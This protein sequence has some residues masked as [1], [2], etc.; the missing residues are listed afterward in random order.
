MGYTF[1][2]PT[3]IIFS[4]SA[5]DDLARELGEKAEGCVFILADSGIMKAGIPEPIVEKIGQAGWKT[6]LY[7]EVKGNP[8]V[9]DVDKAVKVAREAGATHIVSIGGGSVID[10]GKAVSILLTNE[11]LDWEDLQWGRASITTVPLPMAA[12]PTT[13]GTGSEVTHVAVIGDRKGFKKGVVHATIY[14]KLTVVDGGLALTLPAKLTAATGMDVLVHALEAYLGKRANTVSDLLALSAIKAVVQWL[15]VATHHG[16]SLEARRAMAQAATMGGIAFDQ[17]GLGLCHALGGPLATHYH[18]HHGLGVAVL[19][20]ATLLFNSVAIP[21]GRWE[22]L[23]TALAL[24]PTAK[25]DVLHD[26]AQDFLIELGLPTRLS[27]LG[28]E[29]SSIEQM[30]NETTRM[31]MFGNNPR[32]A[33]VEDCCR[34]LEGAL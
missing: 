26:W 14:P 8:N 28:V 22:V 5:G 15:P 7:G 30:A 25:P 16:D 6:V 27:E 24:T 19:L 9:N 1:Y 11:G 34:L 10:T 12:V 3:K 29:H 18:V 2:C 23:R 31:A 20:P 13:A 21:E 17:S 4:D 32:V 33:S